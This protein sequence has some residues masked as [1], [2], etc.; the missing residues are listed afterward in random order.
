MSPPEHSFPR[1]APAS[2]CQPTGSG[3]RDLSY[4]AKVQ[5]VV[6]IFRHGQVYSQS[7]TVGKDGEQD[8]SLEGS[9]ARVKETPSEM[10]SS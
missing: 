10:C 5:G 4:Q 2:G 1:D 9:G 3:I 6:V 7:H 8:D